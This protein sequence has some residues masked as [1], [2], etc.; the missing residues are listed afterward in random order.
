MDPTSEIKSSGLILKISSQKSEV[1]CLALLNDGRL[2]SSLSNGDII[3]YNKI[4]YKIE[5]KIKAH[6]SRI[7]CLTRLSS[8]ILASCSW[9]NT[10]KLFNIKKY[11]YDIFQKFEDYGSN[12]IELENK[13]LVSSSSDNYVI[14]Y[15]KDNNKNREQFKISSKYPCF[16][17]IQTK[18]N[19]ICYSEYIKDLNYNICFYDLNKRCIKASI[20]HINSSGSGGPFNLI[21]KDLLITGGSDEISII[22]V[23]KYKLIRK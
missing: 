13:D 1:S 20:N 5:L 21:G 14:Y 2:V 3:I 18:E 16:S 15:S 8:G 6:K 9:D 19:E 4:T 7:T 17:I 12:I 23:N 10:T 11:R 22:N